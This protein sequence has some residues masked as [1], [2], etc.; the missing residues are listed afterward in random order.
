MSRKSVRY[1]AAEFISSPQLPGV[2]KVFPSPPKVSR[3]GDAFEN[4]PPGTPSGSV[5]YVEVLN[6]EE[7]R[8]AVGGP[9]HG[10]KKATYKLRFHLLFRSRQDTSEAAMDDHDD[11]LD[12]LLVRLRQDRRV[13]AGRRGHP[14]RHRDAEEERNRVDVDLVAGG[15][16]RLGGLRLLTVGAEQQ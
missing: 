7:I 2:G 1:A 4:T 16:E 3:S 5:I 14:V 13:R 6:A 8:L 12:A 15:R 10:V 11:Q 9:H